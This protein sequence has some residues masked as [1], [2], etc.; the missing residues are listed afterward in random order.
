MV[1]VR[2]LGGGPGWGWWTWWWG[3]ETYLLYYAA[4]TWR[5]F[6]VLEFGRECKTQPGAHGSPPACSFQPEPEPDPHCDK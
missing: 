6:G 2:G 4:Y 1:G 3:G 5:F